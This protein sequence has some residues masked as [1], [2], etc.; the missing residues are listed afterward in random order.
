MTYNL[1][2]DG[3]DH[4]DLSETLY[5]PILSKNLNL[6]LNIDIDEYC[7]NFD[8]GCLSFF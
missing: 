3:E 8:N 4:L 1:F 5:I 2:F 6:L 7:F